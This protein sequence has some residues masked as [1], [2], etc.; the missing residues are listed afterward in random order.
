MPNH[1]TNIVKLHDEESIKTFT[2]LLVTTNEKGEEV[3][4]FNNIIPEPENNEDWYNWRIEHWGTK[5]NAYETDIVGYDNYLKVSFNT[6]WSCPFPVFEKLAKLGVKF[7]LAFA[8]EDLG[9]NLGIFTTENNKLKEI[10]LSE[11]D[12]SDLVMLSANI[13]G[14]FFEDVKECFFNETTLDLT[15]DRF[16][17]V[18]HKVAQYI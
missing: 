3:V 1:I 15:E 14:Y 13:I 8:D 5:W 12:Q 6:A 10:D 11:L 16:D 4:T 2:D 9:Y 18:F 17:E 7:T